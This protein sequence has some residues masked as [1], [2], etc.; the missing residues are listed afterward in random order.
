MLKI[1][2][3]CLTGSF[4]YSHSTLSRRKVF[5]PSILQD[6]PH[7]SLKILM[8]PLFLSFLLATHIPAA[9]S[10]EPEWSTYPF[11]PPSLPIAVKSPYLN[12][13]ALQGDNLAQLSELWPK[14]PAVNV[15]CVLLTIYLRALTNIGPFL[16][17]LI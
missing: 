12:A 2:Y 16:N 13:W 8:L 17:L 4:I 14:T 1:R 9:N 3:V 5:L 7:Y 11:Y 15:S 6:N 10:Q